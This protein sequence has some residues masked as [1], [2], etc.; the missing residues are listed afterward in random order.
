MAKKQRFPLIGSVLGFLVFAA[1]PL[2][3]VRAEF[4]TPFAI[5][6]VK[7]V[8]GDS[9]IEK[10][11]ILIDEGRIVAA[12][13]K[14]E[15]PPYAERLDG[16]ELIAYP[17]F[18]DALSHMGIPEKERTKEERERT[19]DENPDPREGP[20]S[21]TRLANR[22]GIRPQ[23]RAIELYNA[24]E[25]QRE[26]FRAVGF[27]T[28]LLAPRDGIFSGTSDM[29]NLSDAPL[30]RA[31]LASDVAMHGSFKTGEPGE[32]PQSLLGIIAQYRQ[33]LLDA[34]W[35]AKS[36]KYA[37]RHPN[38]GDRPPSDAALD[39]LQPLLGRGQ[40]LFFEANSEN[41]IRRALDLAK[42]FNL[43]IGISGAREAWKVLDRIKAERVPLIVSLKFPEEPE[44]G[45]KKKEKSAG[46]KPDAKSATDAP[47]SAAPSES[48]K[49]EVKT[50]DEPDAE[51]A[52]KK[53]EDDDKKEE[54]I[55]EPLKVRK[56]RRRLWEEQ[57]ANVIR[58]H[59]AGVPFSFTTREF[60]KPSEFWDNLRLVIERGLPESAALAALTSTAA[61]FAPKDQLGTIASGRIANVTLMTKPFSDKEA[62]VKYVIIDGKKIEIESDKDDDK[63]K[64]A[65]PESGEKTAKTDAPESKPEAKTNP[66]EKK[67]EAAEEPDRS[68]VFDSE[69]LADRI[70]KTR[71]DG[72]VFIRNATILPVTSPPI[73]DGC[74]LIRKGKIEAI[75]A[76]LT[77]PDGVTVIDATG[78]YVMPG[79]VDPHSHLGIDGVNESPFPLSAE[80]KIVDTIDPHDVAIFRANAGG[81]T[82]HHAM[83]GSANPIGGQ[84]VTFKL[85]YE[86]PVA[87]M[88]IPDA[89]RTIKFALGE[90]VTQANFFE[91]FG[92]RYPNTRMGVEAT[93]RMSFEAAR[94][95][96]RVWDEFE[97]LSKAGQDAPPPRRDLRLE[98]L[99]DVLAGKMTIHSHC[100][101]SEEILRL[102]D[103][104]EEYGV[105]IGLLHHVLEG[106]RI[107]PEMAR[108][109]CGGSSFAYD[110][111]YKVEAYGALPH[112]AALM[113]RNSVN[114]SIN[115]DSQTTIRYMNQEAA[116]CMRWGGL[117]DNEA[118]RLIT[119]NPALQLQV[120]HRIGSLEVGKDGDVAVFNG[121]PV[122]T[123]AKCVMTLIDGEVVFEDARP[124]AVEPVANW[125]PTTL[126]REESLNRQIP[127]TPHRAYAIVGATVHTISGPAIEEG[128]VVIL[129]DRIHAV[130]VN[131]PVPPG[132]GVI[133]AAGLHVY[134]GLIDAGGTLGLNE[135]DS[136]RATRDFREIGTF[137]PHLRAASAV[138]PHSSHIRNTR[139][140]GTTT[141]LTKPT[142]GL[143]SGQS[144]LIH[145][146]G[147][148]APEMLVADEIGLHISVPSL[149][150]QLPEDPERRKERQTEH[151][152]QLKQL[153]NFVTRAKHYDAVKKVAAERNDRH[154]ETDLVLEAMIPYVRGEKPVILEAS[155]YKGILDAI[156]FAEKQG[157]RI[158]LS[159]G[160]DAWKL[161]SILKEKNIPVILGT[162]LSYPRGEFEPWDAVYRCAAELDQA[163][164]RFCFASESSTGAFDLG[165]MVGMA[166]AHGLP[167]E[168]AEYA[169]TLGAADILGIAD[170]VGS[171][172]PG[173]KADLIVT[174][175]SP[176]RTT[177]LVTHMFIDGRPIELTSM[178]T[179]GYEKF[180]NRPAPKLPPA[181]DDLRGPRS[182]TGK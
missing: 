13:A 130:G 14:V 142:G 53:K 109:G 150:V 2:A 101:R 36:L 100:Y 47:E 123:F 65:K 15:I 168:R 136:I 4:T 128:T 167:R 84:N 58:L 89:A 164:V 61:S 73:P 149:P 139:V 92:K 127:Q 30:R 144:A 29:V 76:G 93:I 45:K 77:P 170:R 40:K 159:G 134:P 143:I 69:I 102:I 118:L 6:D 91:N 90:N 28:A 172:E 79:I 129:D 120:D 11:V 96:Q 138:H 124:D 31:I 126:P 108:H 94:E 86:R 161:A 52:E 9:V 141:A 46:K 55:Y 140:V 182:L 66:V 75:G 151:K 104:A 156:E 95:Y 154:F 34:K 70:P 171:I 62:K 5:T 26:S 165:T 88:L 173:K 145:L 12:G 41:E 152:K 155:S 112:N 63:K 60:K 103:V 32:Y 37:E 44:Y 148:T 181:R 166:V 27:T 43:D 132:A 105:R 64:D 54:K 42:E 121:H 160:A 59:E 113:M 38:S 20:A 72:N 178:H 115:S 24:D 162:P 82:T 56:E 78:R 116:K 87:E 74:L 110:W 16:K 179:E 119:I 177:T 80:T 71:T 23:L 21:G 10:G 51:S 49:D 81:V 35:H 1:I 57:V 176:L 85:K 25:K 180:K 97:K 33:V 175:D 174:V 135:I 50:G 163:G 99:A 39:A 68:P 18:I 3:P 122:D 125:S 158:M 147:W 67:E 157:F 111:A 106:Y 107:A 48:K 7:I 131:V 114:A 83:H 153:E 98:A 146:D 117:D 169:V 22:R 133:Q 8:S 17:G 137:N 19:E